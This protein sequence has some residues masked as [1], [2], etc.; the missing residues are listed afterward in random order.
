M[1]GPSELLILVILIILILIIPL[2]VIL[3][4]WKLWKHVRGRSSKVRYGR[5]ITPE[6]D[7]MRSCPKCGHIA[8]AF[9]TSCPMCGTKFKD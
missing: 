2:I 6:S 3:I 8:K 5:V 1:I 7:L 9:S 4:V